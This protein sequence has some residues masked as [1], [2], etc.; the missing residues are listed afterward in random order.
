MLHENFQTYWLGKPFLE[1]PDDRAKA[2]I[3]RRLPLWI[4]EMFASFPQFCYHDGSHV[5]HSD[6]NFRMK[7]LEFQNLGNYTQE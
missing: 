5:Q 2:F 3:I 6:H 4:I 7:I 1:S